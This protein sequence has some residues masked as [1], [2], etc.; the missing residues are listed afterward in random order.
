MK[1]RQTPK[2]KTSPADDG[3]PHRIGLW[4]I[5][6]AALVYC[7]WLGWHWLPLGYTDKELAGS[8]SRVWD[9]K[10]E[11]AEHGRLSWWTPYFMSGSS[12]ALNYS[13]GFYLLPW[14]VFSTFTSLDVA[15][16]L[17]ALCAIFASAVTMYFCAR[18]FLR[19]EWAA[20]LAGIAY[21]LCPE[22][23]TRAATE[24][25]MTISLFMPFVPLLWWLF[26]RMLQSGRFRDVFWCALAFVFAMW[27][28]YKQVFVQGVFLFG[29]LLYWLWLPE[30]RAHRTRTIRTCVL[31]GVAFLGLGAAFL[32]PGFTESKY[33]KLFAG[34]PLEGWQRT[35]AFKS[36]LALVDRDGAATREALTGVIQ[37]MRSGSYHPTSQR[38]AAQLQMQLARIG[39]MRMDSP[40]K[41][42]GLVLLALV[43][44]AALFNHRRVDRSLFW[45]CVGAAMA[46]VSLGTG[47]NSV[48]ST[49]WDTFA[50]LMDLD[51]VPMLPRLAVLMTLAVGVAG[52]VLFA[53]RKL[54][55][56]R[57]W[58]IA[59]GVLAAFLF[60]PVFGLL[61]HLPLF[62]E[63]R[64][65]GVFYGLP[66]S[67]LGAMLAGFFVT[68]VLAA[69]KRRAHIP[70]VVAM[71]GALMVMD[72]WPYQ[73]AMHTNSID[74]QT[75]IKL[76]LGYNPSAS[77]TNS[78]PTSERTLKNLEATYTALR[79]DPN[80]VKTYAI[81]GRYFHL[82]GPIYS[83]KP[84]VYEA[85]YNWM[86]P[87]GTGLLTQTG[88][89]S[90]EMLDLF[91][92][93][94]V[95]F[96]KTD[97]DMQ[98][99][100]LQQLLAAYRH[101]FPIALENTDFVVFR[102]DAAHP[103]VT[104]YARACL[105]DGDIHNSPPFALELE[106]R[107]WPLVHGT[108]RADAVKYESVY[109]DG[110]TPKWPLLN[111]EVVPFTDVQLAR[112]DAQRVRIRLTAPRDCLVVIAESY[113][114][115]WHAAVDGKPTEVLRVSCA[116]MGVNLPAG[117]HE[118][119]LRYEP[120]RGY[121]LAGVLSGLALVGCLVGLIW[122]SG[123]KP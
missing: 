117:A 7:F 16:K 95:I 91:G 25:H 59:G 35:Y 15:G 63:I 85:F 62:K 107:N 31:L 84:Q 81:S 105:F 121:A 17:M 66:F 69:E 71:V 70:K 74:E 73:K 21:M 32:V 13:R 34:D 88:G 111:G 64:A 75:L 122:E 80:W 19:N 29:Y 50:A 90:R 11:L 42:A 61:A 24:E 39:S 100:Q 120:P 45:F 119:V 28:D 9:V 112:E 92:A 48:A 97:P 102:N 58:A 46:S 82:L 106:A 110:E 60:L 54:T 1:T 40:E 49:S 52:L 67:F 51:G 41:Y 108:A 3:A 78:I 38:E 47:L 18:H 101:T 6:A 27:T 33:V 43:G 2:N 83:G 57:K 89:G 114:P 4:I 96:D 22:Q 68:D 87:L 36:V 118:I 123:R 113:Y 109:R 86:A 55:T 8:A 77:A 44:W 20:V 53:R 98:A 37:H 116:F 5:L 30:W 10:R 76:E 14:L 26:A 93:R 65:P 56:Q 104:G 12:Y 115:Y 103:Y 94:Y 72:Y 99:P 23:L 79:K